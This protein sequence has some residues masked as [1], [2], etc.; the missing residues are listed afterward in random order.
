MLKF[1]VRAAIVIAAVIAGVL[2]YAAARPD[3]FQIARSIAIKAPPEKIFP[4]INDPH[5][6]NT[7]NPFLKMDPATKLAYRGPASG[8][9][10][11]HDWDGNS[12]VGKGSL[13]ITDS[14][15]S[16]RIVMKLDMIKPMEAHN[17]VE[18]TLEPKGDATQVTWVMSGP[19]PYVAKVMS[20]V[21]S[22]DRMV[23]GEFE[24]GLADL[25]A[26]AEK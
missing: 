11:G 26:Q 25:K 17:R 8:K 10:A 21:F 3:T 12:Q 2:A 16:S 4:M 5:A 1:V 18:F 15:P 6:F 20:T 24:K 9:G 22:M 23:G 13:E 14:L 7:W 19:S